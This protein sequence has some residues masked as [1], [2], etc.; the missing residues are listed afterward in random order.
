M[1]SWDKIKVLN[2]NVELNK[3]VKIEVVITK[4][5]AY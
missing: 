1:N 4:Q 5:S 2:G 3:I